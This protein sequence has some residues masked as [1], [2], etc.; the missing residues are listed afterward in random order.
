MANKLAYKMDFSIFSNIYRFALIQKYA[1]NP[2]NAIRS[3]Y[4]M[5]FSI[6]SNIYRF[7]LIQNYYTAAI[8]NIKLASQLNQVIMLKVN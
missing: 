6:F 3:A 2:M 8:P 1:L 5:D 7:A 4:V